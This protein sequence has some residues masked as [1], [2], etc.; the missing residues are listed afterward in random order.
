MF[1]TAVIGW[2]KNLIR[3]MQWTSMKNVVMKDAVPKKCTRIYIPKTKET[4]G[5]HVQTYTVIV[6]TRIS[7]PTPLSPEKAQPSNKRRST[8]NIIMG[9]KNKDVT[10]FLR[11][12][13][14]DLLLVHNL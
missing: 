2:K 13:E 3:L 8:G 4:M 14:D 6:F 10:N 7:T 1:F 9:K 11:A 5:V 12:P